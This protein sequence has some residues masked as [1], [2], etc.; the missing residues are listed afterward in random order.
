M[1]H[2]MSILF[3]LKSAKASKKSL[4]PI[5]QRITINVIRIE[6]STTKFVDKAKWN[7]EAC[8]IKKKKTD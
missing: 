5:Y 4:Y 2:K 1:K 3:Y 8:R 6:L 7:K